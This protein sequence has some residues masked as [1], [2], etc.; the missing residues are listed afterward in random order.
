M[1]ADNNSV[2]SLTTEMESKSKTSSFTSINNTT[3]NNLLKNC[4]WLNDLLELHYFAYNSCNSLTIY[5]HKFWHN[6]RKLVVATKENNIKE[7]FFNQVEVVSENDQATK[8][9][10]TQSS[11]SSGNS[12][13]NPNPNQAARKASSFESKSNMSINDSDG[14]YLEPVYKI[15][16]L[17]KIKSELE[18]N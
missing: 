12:N 8:I 3:N 16:K 13:S 9:L 5:S 11:I 15:H 7:V 14:S 6:S 18:I 1:K 10:S 4:D 2:S 17:P